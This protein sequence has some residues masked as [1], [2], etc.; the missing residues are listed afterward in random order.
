LGQRIDVE[1]C[2]Q[3]ASSYLHGSTYLRM[4]L[5]LLFPIVT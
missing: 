4:P 3:I 5:F 2:D 1:V